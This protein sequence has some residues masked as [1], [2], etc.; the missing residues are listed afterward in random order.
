MRYFNSGVISIR[1]KEYTEFEI[2]YHFWKEKIAW[3][4]SWSA[5]FSE[6]IFSGP[7]IGEES[8]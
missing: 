1:K 8:T 4:M 5:R 7:Q 6:S 2:A 3:A